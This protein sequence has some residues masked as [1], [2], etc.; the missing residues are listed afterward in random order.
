ME[1]EI[2]R[3]NDISVDDSILN[4]ASTVKEAFNNTLDKGLNNLNVEA[5][6]LDKVKEG[7]KKVNVKEVA[8]NTI[9]TALKS[10]LKMAVGAKAK[11]VDTFK[12]I[13]KAIR[14]CDL[15]EGLKNVVHLGV[16]AIKGIPTSIKNVVKDGV[17]L[18]LGDTFDDELQKVMVKQK[19]TLSRL[20]KKCDN[21]EKALNDNNEKDMKK[22]IKGINSDLEKISLISNTIDR[23]KGIL[24]QYELMQNK[25]S[26]E[27]NSIEQELCKKLA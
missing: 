24:N 11:T 9:D 4:A 25:G 26:T 1:L 18:V 13:G 15:K 5:G 8:S 10:T 27:L 16:D 19:N 3:N 21:F 22:Y 6:M 14:D 23:A 17:D 7:L 12:N 2:T 20:D